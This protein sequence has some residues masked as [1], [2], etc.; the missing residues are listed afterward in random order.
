[1][2]GYLLPF[3]T[4]NLIQLKLEIPYQKLILFKILFR[5]VHYNRKIKDSSANWDIGAVLLRRWLHAVHSKPKL[6]VRL[7][8]DRC[9]QPK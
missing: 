5:I 2:Y 7:R 1:M 4:L 8:P 9:K 3:S 6:Q